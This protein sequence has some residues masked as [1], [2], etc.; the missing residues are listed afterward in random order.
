MISKGNELLQELYERL[1]GHW[2]NQGKYKG[3]PFNQRQVKELM[4]MILK[5]YQDESSTLQE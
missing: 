5:E 4:E 1:T 2:H 3:Q